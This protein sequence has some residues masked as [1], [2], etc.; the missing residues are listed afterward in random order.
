MAGR[1]KVVLKSKS[2]R[3]GYKYDIA[4]VCWQKNYSTALSRGALRVA[5]ALEVKA[6]IWPAINAWK[7]CEPG[8]SFPSA[9]I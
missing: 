1:A 7:R 3:V 9:N 8:A 5:S 4:S 2:C 6:C